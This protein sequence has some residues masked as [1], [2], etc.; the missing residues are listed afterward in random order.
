MNVLWHH[1]IARNDEGKTSAS[2][3]KG[4]FIGIAGFVG[5]QIRETVITTEGEKVEVSCLLTTDESAS[6]HG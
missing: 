6:H 4:G 2:A 1:D 3:L 5:I